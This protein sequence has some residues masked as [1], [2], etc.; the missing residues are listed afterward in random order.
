MRKF[1]IAIFCLL[2]GC[3][4]APPAP[5]ETPL[6]TA[7]GTIVAFGDSL[8]AGLGLDESDAYPAQLQRRI[9]KDGFEWKVVNAGLSGETSTAARERVNWVMKLKPRLVILETGANDGLR[10][11]EPKV[12][13]ENLRAMI[14]AFKKQPG[15]RVLLAGMRSPENMGGDYPT[16]FADVYP[17]VAKLENVALIPFFLDGVAADP[18]LNQEDRM[19]PT[20]EGYAV[21]VDK[22]A[23][24]VEGLL[25][26]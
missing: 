24:Q 11:I 17:R 21:I 22:I 10:G 15:V 8:T 3:A 26:P 1:S 19:H 12:T 7:V 4:A 5:T 16:R 9:Y 13:E 23:P 14:G 2:A 25:K 20:K 6:A 18:D